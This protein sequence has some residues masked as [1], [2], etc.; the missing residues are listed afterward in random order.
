MMKNNKETKRQ[1]VDRCFDSSLGICDNCRK[2]RK[3]YNTG[4]W[5]CFKCM[6][7]EDIK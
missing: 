4:S 5:L 2:Q 6:G 3:R 7:K 1:V